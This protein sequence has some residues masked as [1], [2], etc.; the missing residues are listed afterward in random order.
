MNNS[1]AIRIV[2]IVLGLLAII[3]AIVGWRM[4]RSF[5][6]S[7]SKA[8]EQQPVSAAPAVPQIMVVI[9]TRPLA[10][11]V[12]IDRDAIVLAPV[13]IAPTEYFA[14]VDDA[15]GR[16]P[17]IDV[18]AGAPVVP[19][20]FKDAN[21]IARG[22]PDGFRALSLKVDDVVG[23][24]GFVRPGDTVD[25][26]VYI[27]SV[28]D[29]PT[30]E[31]SGPDKTEDIPTQARVLIRDIRVL[32]YEDHLVEPPK[33]I[34]E[35]K[36]KQAQ[37]QGRR[38]RTAVLA[39]PEAQVTK[40]L[41]GSSYG[42]LRLALHGTPATT[43]AAAEARAPE[44]SAVSTTVSSLPLSPEAKAKADAEA[45]LAAAQ[46]ITATELTQLI[47]KGKKKVGRSEGPPRIEIYRGSDLKTVS[48]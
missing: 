8:Q 19:R 47:A 9:A 16:T 3:L 37:N 11:N 21:M 12:P 20:F 7:A 28:T 29:T 22:V 42:E 23:V 2:A 31:K 36:D 38:E 24:G 35:N 14:N 15:I 6:E 1:N 32:A 30:G 5:A 34:P 4:S 39:I 48:P 45:E 13:T 44:I 27:K 33:G 43:A 17:L 10:A 46:I 41:L 18:D 25:V 26:L 40:V